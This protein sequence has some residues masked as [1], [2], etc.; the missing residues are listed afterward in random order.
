M[1][2]MIELAKIDDIQFGFITGKYIIDVIFISKRIH[3]HL[4]KQR[5]LHKC[6]VGLENAFDRVQ[7][8]VM[9]WSMMKKRVPELAMA[10]T[11]LFIG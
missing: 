6:F 5:K 2:I 8:K 10:V 3:K 7:R 4:A 9:E 1:K 11:S